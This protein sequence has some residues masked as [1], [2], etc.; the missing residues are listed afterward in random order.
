MMLP[1]NRLVQEKII[2]TGFIYLILCS[3]TALLLLNSCESPPPKDI[4]RNSWYICEELNLA[5]QFQTSKRGEYIGL[6]KALAN[7]KS[8]RLKYYRK[9]SRFKFNDREN[10]KGELLVQNDSLI[11]I[12]EGQTYIFMPEA[13]IPLPKPPHRYE[14]E[15]FEEVSVT[16][17]IYGQARGF[18]SSKQIEKRENKSY[19]Q[20]IF[21]VAEEL[22]SN[23]MKSEIPLQLDIY[24][25][26]GDE[27]PNRPLIVL[28]H[29]GAFIAGD[30]RDELVS[31]LAIHYAKRGFVVA[32]VN[33]RLG[34]LFL[35][36]R[37]AN[38]E[39]AM[40]SAIQ[41]IRAALRYLSHH[42]NQYRIDTDYIYLGGNSAGG[43]LSL[44]TAF[45]KES[46]VW[47]SAGAG[48]LGLRRDLGCLDCS[49]N[50]LYGPFNIQAVINMWGAVHSLD[51]L[52]SCN[53][54]ILS[55]HGDKDIV[56]PY[57]H[58]YPFTDVSPKVSAFFS[59]KL[60]GSFSIHNYADTTDLDHTLF[61]F[62]GLKHE[63]HFDEDHQ[64]ITEN[65][66]I[67]HDQILHFINKQLIDKTIRPLGPDIIVPTDAP[68]KYQAEQTFYKQVLFNCNHCLILSQTA[69]A[70]EIIWLEGKKDYTLYFAAVGPHGQ[71]FA[72]SMR[73][74]LKK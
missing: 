8:F 21:D 6:N 38:L 70:A 57:G 30:K 11:F 29:G 63:P 32:S 56:V 19:G 40:Y 71:V 55:I 62:E 60:H 74:A 26:I 25:A 22:G 36:G 65:Y 20:V 68:G 47:P 16:E 24:Q 39:R 5:L 2:G 64:M 33:Y 45:M 37:Y 13:R 59:R 43:I 51:I 61:T 69:N 50:D 12:T 27:E 34:Y 18:Y 42:S 9:T 3:I 73:I 41:D 44:S 72:D 49:T 15:L 4:S 58:D 35:P 48:A 7:P 23:L 66:Q 46:D 52:D 31:T 1:N 14:N 54:P 53:I 28:I 10:L 17:I 67:I